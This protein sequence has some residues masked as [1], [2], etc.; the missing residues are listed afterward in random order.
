MKRIIV[1]FVMILS[2]ALIL[3]LSSC[4][5][6]KH[7]NLQ[8]IVTDPTCTEKGYTTF[9]CEECG[10]GYFGD[11]T[12]V[13]NHT[14]VSTFV[15]PTAKDNGYTEHTCTKCSDTYRD[16]YVTPTE[17]KVTSVNRIRIGYTGKEGENLVIPSVFEYKGTWYRV[18]LISDYAFS[19][20]KNLASVVIPDSVTAID[21]HAFHACTNLASV[22]IG[23]NVSS[24]GFAAFAEATSLERITIPQS[25]TFI[26]EA[27]FVD[28]S[29]V[30]SITVDENNA[31]YSSIDGNLY[32]K[33]GKTFIQYALG[34]T[35]TSF[36]IPDGVT[37]IGYGAFGYHTPNYNLKTI[38]I[39]NSVT[40]IGDFAFNYCAGL[41][42]I[43]I[44]DSVTTIGE[45]AFQ[46]CISL[47]DVTISNN[48]TNIKNYAFYNCASLTSIVL[49]SGVKSVGYAT[50]AN[51]A[52]LNS[53]VIPKSV[54]TIGDY[55]F[56]NCSSLTGIKYRGTEAEWN[57]ISKGS[58]W[59]IY[60][61][62]YTITYNY[63]DE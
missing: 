41:T 39:P 49:P 5:K 60:T 23:N 52:S 42:R 47:T 16:S 43:V 46:N 27:A 18:T 54:T 2:L 17:F 32:S 29:S 15:P 1:I 20:C 22:T 44:P 21:K 61:G 24:I 45:C 55:A 4:D 14:Y 36:K 40:T 38:L 25:V 59:D 50:F 31:N 3:N 6:C 12:E 62:D 35:K 10:Y 28:C 57:N 58:Y 13:K 53:I 9:I 33:D 34:K 48:V 7:D 63:T 8:S 56:F 30:T 37:C 11:I 26:D 19:N 51:C